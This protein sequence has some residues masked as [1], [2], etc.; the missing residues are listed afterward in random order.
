MCLKLRVS[1]ETPVV[2]IG[3]VTNLIIPEV[4]D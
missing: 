1:G 4:I 2:L 3:G